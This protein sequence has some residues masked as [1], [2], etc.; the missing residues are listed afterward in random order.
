MAAL[1]PGETEAISLALELQTYGVMLD[2]R[3]ARHLAARL[4]LHVAGTIRV[5]LEAKAAGLLPV[6]RPSINALL[7]VGFFVSAQIVDEALM[8]AGESR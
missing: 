7:D 1:E 3:Q 5:L 6:V 2:D 8:E 4:G